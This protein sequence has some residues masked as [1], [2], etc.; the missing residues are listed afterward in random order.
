VTPSDAAVARVERVLPAPPDVVFREWLDADALAEWMCPR[1]ARLRA[2]EIDARPDGGFRF[3]IVEGDVS[4]SVTGRYVK[5]EPPH[6]LSFTWSCST[7]PDPTL[8]T[9]VTVSLAAHGAR[10]TLMTIE[11]TLLPPD[12][13]ARHEAGWAQISAQLSAVVGA[14]ERGIKGT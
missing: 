3:D 13:V 2:V 10:D 6:H 7:W 1:P 14:R 5:I 11:H 8:E 4:F 9:I 12:L